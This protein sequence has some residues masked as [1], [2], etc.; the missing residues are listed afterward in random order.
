MPKANKK[1]KLKIV[2]MRMT[3]D[4]YSR[5]LDISSEQDVPNISGTVRDLVLEALAAR[6][7]KKTS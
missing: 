7:K 3:A 6:K 2:T 1:S 4:T 5:V